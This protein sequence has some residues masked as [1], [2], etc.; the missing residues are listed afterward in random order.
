MFDDNTVQLKPHSVIN[1]GP[2]ICEHINRMTAI[3]IFFC[4]VICSKG[5]LLNFITIIR[6]TVITLT[7]V[8]VLG[9]K[10]T[11]REDS[12][13]P[14]KFNLHFLGPVVETCFVFPD[15]FVKQCRR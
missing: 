14:F 11:K 13:V 9:K 2:G 7:A 5:E 10:Y 6:L 3:I 8:T 1:L 15:I 4:A 12:L